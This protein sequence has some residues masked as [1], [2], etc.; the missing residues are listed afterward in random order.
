M[1][2]NIF[3]NYVAPT[4]TDGTHTERCHG[5]VPT[6]RGPSRPRVRLTSLC[7]AAPRTKYVTLDGGWTEI[8][9]PVLAGPPG[10]AEG[11]CPS[12]RYNAQ[13]HSRTT[14]RTLLVFSQPK[15]A[16][17]QRSRSGTFYHRPQNY[18]LQKSDMKSSLLD[19]SSSFPQGPY[20]GLGVSYM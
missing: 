12:Y 20:Y 2:A 14:Q 9:C 19:N 1:I 7:R 11:P 16:T 8:N 18:F 13:D 17:Q 6:Q 3:N 10:D 4:W 15:F 5:R